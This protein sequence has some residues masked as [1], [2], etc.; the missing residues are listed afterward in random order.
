MQKI[1]LQG[2]PLSAQQARI[3]ALQKKSPVYRTLCAVHL[4]G[5][6]DSNRLKMAVSSIVERHEILR[7]LFYTLPSMDVPV[8][9]I[10]PDPLWSYRE[11]SLEQLDT[12]NQGVKRDDLFT[13]LQREPVDLQQGPLL[14][15]WL[16]RLAADRHL[17][18]VSLPAL[19]A[20]SS[21]TK[22]FMDELTRAYAREALTEEVLQY[23]DIAAW[24]EELLKEDEEEDTH[25]YWHQEK[26]SSMLNMRLPFER[27]VKEMEIGRAHV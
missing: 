1:G 6:V 4:Q 20:D 7:T 27:E 26:L 25:Q 17:L 15:V 12:V 8:Q 2:S 19:C 24:Q 11:I 5:V 10:R 14:H 16:C 18:L 9:I 21:S 3:W 22:L 13:S 23:A